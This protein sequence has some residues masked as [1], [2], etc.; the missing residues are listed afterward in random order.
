MDKEKYSYRVWWSEDEGAYIGTVAE[1]P[2]LSH[3]DDTQGGAFY[4]IVDLVGSVL[5]EMAQT[6]DVAPRPLGEMSFSGT[7]SLRMTPEQHRRVALE[8]AEQGVSINKLLTS[9]I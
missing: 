3:I 4:G 8:A 1:F 6:G 2:S 7:L 9:R 5:E